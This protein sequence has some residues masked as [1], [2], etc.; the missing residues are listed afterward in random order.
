MTLFISFKSLTNYIFINSTLF[1]ISFVHYY[2]FNRYKHL[3]FFIL[4]VRNY[5][6]INF[7]DYATKYQKNIHKQ[8]TGN[9]SIQDYSLEIHISH[10]QIVLLQTIEIYTIHKYL[11]INE[12]YLFDITTFIPISFLYEIIFDFCHYWLHRIC[13]VNNFL[14]I[15]IHKKH[16]KHYNLTSIVTFY[17]NPLDFVLTGIIPEMITLYILHS[18]FFKLSGFQFI[19]IL[20]YKLFSEIAGHSGKHTN[21]CGFVQFIWLPRFLNIEIHTEDHDLHHKLLLC[22]Y[23]KRFIIWDKLFNTY[24]KPI[25]I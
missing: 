11:S 5:F 14:Y 3:A 18:L 8:I 23:S 15:N 13:H 7:I 21:S 16:H 9:N 22:N 24:T 6:I 17:Q 19:L 4:L 2:M 10:L 1:F 12:N 25:E 20:N